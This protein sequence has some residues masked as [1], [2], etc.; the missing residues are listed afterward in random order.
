MTVYLEI[1]EVIKQ[2]K[3]DYEAA[4]AQENIYTAYLCENGV[5]QMIK[6]V[7]DEDT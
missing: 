6:K 2:S 3:T 5:E 7:G 4:K 1:F